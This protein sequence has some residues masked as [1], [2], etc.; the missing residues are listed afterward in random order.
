MPEV[1]S[2]AGIPVMQN[3]IRQTKGSDNILKEQVRD[4]LCGELSLSHKARHKAH[5]FQDSLNA[6]HHSIETITQWQVGHK[7]NGPM[8]KLSARDWQW[9]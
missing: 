3:F 4:L 8:P 5:I 9:V 6:S 7:V 1:S 2:E